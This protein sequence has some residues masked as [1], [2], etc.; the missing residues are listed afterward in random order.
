MK[1][2]ELLFPKVTTQTALMTAAG[3]GLIALARA[4]Y[5]RIN[6][7][8]LRDK[9]VLITGGSRGLGLELARVLAAKGAKIAI[10]ARNENQLEKAEYDEELEKAGIFAIRADLTNELE[11][12]KVVDEVINHFGRIDLLINNAGTM[13]VGPENLMEIDD[14]QQVMDANLWSALYMMKAA[15]PHFRAQ[16]EGH[17]A[18]ICSIGGK[19]AV[20]HMLPYSVSKFAMV[21]LS[22]GMGVELKKDNI[23]VTTVIPNLMRTGSPMNVTVKGKHESEYEWFKLA[24]SLPFLSQDAKVAAKEIVTAIENGENEIVLTA[25]GKVVTALK[26]IMPGSI[27]T[28]T[29]FADR[30]FPRSEN[31]LAKK[32]YESESDATHGLVGSIT[33]AAA[34]RNNEY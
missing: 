3:I 31:K 11:A 18:N 26:G 2:R 5:V 4:V 1:N 34:A 16:G 15:L 12:R 7:F 13:I 25:T 30:F 27:T 10:C 14:Y 6:R 24:D 8:E 32:G 19:I 21:G 9:V 20:P 29:Q 22:E 33:D 23:H 17:I 28:L